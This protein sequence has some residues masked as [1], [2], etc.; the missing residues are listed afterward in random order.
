MIYFLTND[1]LEDV[2]DAVREKTGSTEP[3]VIEEAAD[4]IRNIK[5]TGI[6]TNS[7]ELVY[8]ANIVSLTITPIS[9]T[10]VA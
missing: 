9:G 6:K 3:I 8:G 7:G 5:N 1:T 2:C 10:I 4:A